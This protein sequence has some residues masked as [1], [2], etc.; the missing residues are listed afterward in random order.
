[1]VPCWVGLCAPTARGCIGALKGVLAQLLT[2][3]TLGEAVEAEVSLQLE[4]GGKGGQA[5]RIGE[6]LGL[7]AGNCVDN[8]GACSDVGG[9]RKDGT[10]VGQGKNRDRHPRQVLAAKPAKNP[11]RHHFRPVSA[12]AIVIPIDSRSHASPNIVM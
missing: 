7:W 5:G 11:A 8:G 9:N 10:H 4:G 12:A 2:V 1:M 3:G 6:V